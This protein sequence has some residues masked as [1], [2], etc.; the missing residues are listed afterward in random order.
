MIFSIICSDHTPHIFWWLSIQL[1]I[2][3]WLVGL[4]RFLIL[5]VPY[6]PP[7]QSIADFSPVKCVDILR[8]AAGLPSMQ[9]DIKT[10]RTWS[11]SAQVAD[12]F[13]VCCYP[14]VQHQDMPDTAQAC[15]QYF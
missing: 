15:L 10:V 8:K 4:R 6:F 14:T 5:Q 12:N 3:T 7:V 9:V 11:M 1:A 2:S 13:Q